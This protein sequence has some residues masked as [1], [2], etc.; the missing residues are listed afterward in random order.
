MS[1]TSKQLELVELLKETL[2]TASAEVAQN[3]V[4]WYKQWV[5][6]EKVAKGGRR[7]ELVEGEKL[8]FECIAPSGLNEGTNIYKPSETPAI[9]KRVWLEEWPEWVQPLG[10]HDAY[11][12]DAKV[13]HKGK[14]W[15][16]DVDNN[17]WEPGIHG[18][19][20]VKNV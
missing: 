8:L 20:E 14:K 3:N 15:T 19:T 12:K 4:E 5:Y 1:L 6:G 7:W 16:S 2:P 11:A 18:W 10:A 13:T 9:W 17:I